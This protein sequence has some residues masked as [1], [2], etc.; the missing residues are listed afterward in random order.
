M[1][2]ESITVPILATRGCPYQ[3]T[4][5]S[6]PNMWL[7]RWIPRDPIKV[8]DEIQYYQ[9]NFNANNF[10]FQDLTAI[11]KKD[12]IKAFCEEIINRKLNITWQLPTGTRSEAIDDEIADLLKKSGMT[13]MAYAPESG[14]EETRKFIKKRMK[15]ENLFK[16]I[17]SASKAKLNIAVFI[18]IGFP[19]DN[20]KYLKENINFI[21]RLADQGVTDM[22]VGYY[23]A[24]PG[25]QLFNSLFDSGKITLDKNYFSHILDSLL[26]FHPKNIAL[27]CQDLNFYTIKYIF[28]TPFIKRRIDLVYLKILSPYLVYYSEKMTMT[29]SFRQLF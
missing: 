22:S 21:K 18:V 27:T 23:M 15:T 4:Y 26:L 13:S 9:D 29:Q 7:P 11:I 17:A 25:T 28:F 3:C 16:S 5:C 24:L 20:D 1:Y 19:H 2:S 14:S 6:A 8:V 10:P 12:W